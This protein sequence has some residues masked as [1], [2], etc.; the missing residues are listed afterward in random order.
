MMTYLIQKSKVT[1]HAEY[2]NMNNINGIPACMAKA[3]LHCQYHT[4]T[5]HAH[6]HEQPKAEHH[7][8]MIR[9]K[10]RTRIALH[11]ISH[12]P[13]VSSN[14]DCL[15]KKS[16]CAELKLWSSGPLHIPFL[17]MLQARTFY[18]HKVACR[19]DSF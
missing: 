11:S 18:Q 13:H 19:H 9:C 15:T 3:Y 5:D 7:H 1:T 14:C 4:S 17:A 12:L 16:I 8:N 6:V 2:V 10:A